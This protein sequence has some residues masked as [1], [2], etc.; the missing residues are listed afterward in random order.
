[1]N[2]DSRKRL[3]GYLGEKWP[4]HPPFIHK[5]EMYNTDGYLGER[6]EPS[7]ILRPFTTW[8]DLGA[9]MEEIVEKG[10]WKEFERYAW[11]KWSNQFWEGFIEWLLNPTRFCELVA[12]W[13][14]GKEKV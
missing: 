7:Y 3:T 14:E 12:D 2:D 10:E 4:D 11:D 9:L 6:E 1:M 8:P 5:Y 13:L